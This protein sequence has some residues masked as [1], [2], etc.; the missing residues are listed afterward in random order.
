MRREDFFEV[1]GNLDDDILKGAEAPV[2]KKVNW[3]AWKTAACIVLAF[4]LAV[5]FF[6]SNNDGGEASHGTADAAPMI[7]VNDALYK[8]SS[9]QQGYPEL[10][11]EFVY[12][13]KIESMTS[14]RC[15]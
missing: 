7:Y 1:L 5:S 15:V 4:A 8:Q 14:E 11:D 10:M 12:L 6:P 13:G 3:K 9:D 2:K